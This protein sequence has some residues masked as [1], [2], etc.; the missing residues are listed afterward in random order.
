MKTL[1]TYS[2]GIFVVAALSFLLPFVA[3][4][5]NG[6]KVIQLTGLELVTG[7][8]VQAPSSYGYGYT[9][10][11]D[12]A[13][14]PLA[15]LA[16]VVTLAGIA[17]GFV[18]G[19]PGSI[20]SAI[21]GAVA[22]ISLLLLQSKLNSDAA[23]EGGNIFKIDYLTGFWIA[24]VLLAIATVLN[25]YLLANKRKVIEPKPEVLS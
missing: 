21:S 15:V 19:G 5:C 11:R 23:R 20:L 2:A 22:F 16:I 9:T 1:P 7:T 3:A 12:V 14:E 10:H 6:Q 25:L 13:P 24:L 8:R 4:S 18:K 17:L